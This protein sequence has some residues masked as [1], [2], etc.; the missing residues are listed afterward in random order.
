MQKYSLYL[1]TFLSLWGCEKFNQK[2]NTTDDNGL[3]EIFFPTD[4][5]NE[6]LNKNTDALL[7]LIETKQG[8]VKQQLSKLN[9]KEEGDLLFSEYYKTLSSIMDSLNATEASTLKNY[10]KWSENQKPDSI[11]V[12]EKR[13][14]K[15]DIFVK[16]K[17][18]NYFEL[19]FT[20]GYYHKTFKNKVSR[21]LQDYLELMGKT[22]RLN[23]EIQ[24]K[25]QE[26]SQI[27]FRKITL[28]WEDYLIK[29]K[30]SPNKEIALKYYTES[31][32]RYLFGGPS[33]SNIDWETKKITA[34]AE[35]ELMKFIKEQPNTQTAKITKDF[36]Q[37]FY[38]TQQ[39][40]TTKDFY[41]SINELVTSHI[42]KGF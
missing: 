1:I 25:K 35:P 5:A 33:V 9:T 34:N 24:M 12:K 32:R 36:L 41:K 4:P 13:F 26:Y 17:D 27:E 38:S 8:E 16:H 31:I 37:F 23:Y 15:L 2:N 19:K 14:K 29:H 7:D 42:N 40:T 18:S 39:T 11:L 10:S 3:T 21:N 28:L 30:N 20:P 22:N 6:L